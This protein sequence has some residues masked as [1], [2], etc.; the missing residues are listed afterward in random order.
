MCV[1]VDEPR[2]PPIAL[3]GAAG[4]VTGVAWCPTDEGQIAMCHDAAAVSVWTL[5][6]SRLKAPTAPRQVLGAFF[7]RAALTGPQL[8]KWALMVVPLLP[9]WGIRRC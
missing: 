1:Q 3:D 7:P 5:D 6:R 4:E 2:R 8:G 9:C